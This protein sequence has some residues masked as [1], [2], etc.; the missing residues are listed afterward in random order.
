MLSLPYI[1]MLAALPVLVTLSGFFS[2]S[3]TS[4]FSLSSHQRL[5][6][7]RGSSLVAGAVSRLLDQ[8]RMLLVTLMLGN[9]L[10][11]VSFFVTSEILLLRMKEHEVVSGWA[12]AALHFVPLWVL[13]MGGEVLP[14]LV[15]SRHAMT[16]ARVTA[17]PLVAAHRLF[18]PVRMISS[19]LVIHPLAR[20]LAPAR[21]QS[22]LSAHELGA[23][24]DL[25]QQRGV[26]DREEEQMLQQ[27]LSLGQMKVQD[28]MTPRVDIVAFDFDDDPA[29]LMEIVRTGPL[30]R[31]V[32]YEGDLDHVMGVVYRRQV[33]LRRP[34]SRDE[35]RSLI[36]QV[37]YVPQI[38]RADALLVD[39]RRR[40]TTI[41]IVVDEYGGTEGLVTL[42]DVVEH[43][44]GRIGES[45]HERPASQVVRLDERTWRVSADLSIREWAGVFGPVAPGQAVSTIGG[46]VMASLGRAAAIG[47]RTRLGNVEIEVET[48]DGRRIESLLI[49]LD[50]TGQGETETA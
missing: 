48:M 14:K 36:R 20:I 12:V 8:K 5:Q 39:L 34:S 44:V 2:G 24:L 43:M 4:F 49:R 21:G 13:I 11:N 47:D 46:M 22:E 40:G 9:M 28:L 3:E 10:V 37:R 30:G 33:L 19:H 38:Q 17:V 32:V 42:E 25:S 29:E 50:Q 45:D 27:V 16:W 18:A 41:A 6:M 31:V 15:A 35:V 23:L 1:L 26:I 7:R